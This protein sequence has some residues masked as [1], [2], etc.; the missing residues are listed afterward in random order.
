MIQHLTTGSMSTNTYILKTSDSQCMVIDPGGDTHTIINNCRDSGLQPSLILC[1]HGHFDHTA[2]VP[3]LQRQITD[4]FGIQPEIAIHNADRHFLGTSAYQAQ[5]EEFSILGQEG[6]MFLDSIFEEP[7]EPTIL[8]SDNQVLLQTGLSVIHTPGHTNGCICLYDND[9]SILIS[10]D[11]LFAG[12]IGRTDF[13]SGNTTQLL[14]SIT[15]KLMKLPQDTVVYPGHGD[16][17]TIGHEVKTNPF[18]K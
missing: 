12:G 10:G 9:N 4:N 18:L 11:T 7:P 8:L 3:S 13:A 14:S 5:K 1:T 2:G 16:T 6:L 17:S 15:N